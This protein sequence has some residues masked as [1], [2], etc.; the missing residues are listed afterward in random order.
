MRDAYACEVRSNSRRAWEAELDPR[1]G[2]AGGA[3]GSLNQGRTELARL[4]FVDAPGGPPGRVR[5]E[6]RTGTF[7]W[8]EF[9]K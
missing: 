5:P 3:D 7:M 2:P 9:R 6:N 1:G 4:W 8:E